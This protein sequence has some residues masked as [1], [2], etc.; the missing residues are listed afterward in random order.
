M[1]APR[2]HTCLTRVVAFPFL[3]PPAFLAKAKI[4]GLN[5]SEL[6]MGCIYL[7]HLYVRH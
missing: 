2:G 5:L 3:P 6:H 4:V 1:G 7:C